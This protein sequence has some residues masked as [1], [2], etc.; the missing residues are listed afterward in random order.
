MWDGTHLFSLSVRNGSLGLRVKV[1]SSSERM[2]KKVR[3]ATLKKVPI[4]LVVGEKEQQSGT[5]SVRLRNG[6]D[7]GQFDLDELS[8]AVI[9]SVEARDDSI[10]LKELGAID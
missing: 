3:S 8:S 9:Q 5:V 2:Q 6:R 10:L 1:D 7:L 4:I